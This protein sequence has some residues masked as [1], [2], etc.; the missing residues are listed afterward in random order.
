MQTINPASQANCPTAG[1]TA[2]IPIIFSVEKMS[3]EKR[4]EWKSRK[5]IV[6]ADHAMKLALGRL[7]THRL[8][9]ELMCIGGSLSSDLQLVKRTS[10]C[11]IAFYRWKS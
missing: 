10:Q 1:A 6:D 4:D 3:N 7:R 9:S 2:P 5:V 8:T 11:L